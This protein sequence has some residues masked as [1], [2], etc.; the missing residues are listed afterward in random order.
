MRVPLGARARAPESPYPPPMPRPTPQQPD[1][2]TPAPPAP[3]PA[4][5]EPA[6]LDELRALLA[7][8]RGATELPWPTL[9]AAIQQEYRVLHLGRLAGEEGARLAAAILDETERLFAATDAPAAPST[10]PP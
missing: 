9:P 3:A 5:P 7:Q 10:N 8:L 4:V 1:L 6:P 2:F